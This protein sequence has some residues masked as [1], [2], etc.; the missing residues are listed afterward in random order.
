M[1]KAIIYIHG[2]GGTPE[3]AS[4]FRP[5]FPDRD[6]IGFDY[7]ADTPWDAK[8]EFTCFL[9][10][11]GRDHASISVI[12]NSIGAFFVMQAVDAVSI[13]KAYFISPIVDMEQL[14]RN[15]M[16]WANVTAEQ[17]SREKEIR[18]D[19]GETLSWDYLCYVQDNPVRWKVPTCILYGEKDHLTTLQTISDFARRSGASLEIMPGGEH[20]FHTDDQMAY[21]D[22]W[23][24]TQEKDRVL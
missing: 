8:A 24:Q 7:K 9:K 2:K 13:E 21:L 23:I 5:L 18:T 4:R 16:L 11:A 17:L 15:M 22:H 3:E 19:F 20:W 14:I 10:E 6:V 12:A 1:K